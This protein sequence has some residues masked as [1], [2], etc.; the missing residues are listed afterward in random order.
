MRKITAQAIGCFL[1]GKPMCSGNT[2]VELSPLGA[3]VVLKLHGNA[4]ARYDVGDIKTLEV[5]N[6]GWSSNTTKERLNGLPGVRVHQKDWDWYLN[7][8]Q[9]DGDWKAVN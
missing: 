5:C 9:W 6:G 3:V 2:S 7:G 4:I 1:T 8:A